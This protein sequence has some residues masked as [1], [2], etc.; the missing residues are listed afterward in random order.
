MSLTLHFHPLSSFCQKVL[1]A[2]YENGTAFTPNLVDL[3]DPEQRAALVAR[4]PIGKFPVLH[5]AQRNA[6]VPESSVIIEYL[7]LHHPGPVRLIPQDEPRALQTRLRDRSFDL[8]LNMA[9]Q[10]VVGDR[11]RPAAQ[12][13]AHGVAEAMRT[14]R[15]ACDMLEA[16]IAGRTWIMGDDFTMADCAA[17]PALFYVDKVMPLADAHRNA[18][19]YLERLMRRPSYARA[20]KEAEPYLRLFPEDSAA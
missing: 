18:A 3:G 12:K 19:A 11:L 2:L 9:M 15:T 1:I 14:L 7:Q 6:S 17:A 4:W 8:Y 16:Q 5:D 13:D 10:K 20:L